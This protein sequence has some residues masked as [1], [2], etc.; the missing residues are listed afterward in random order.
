M[1]T[2]EVGTHIFLKILINKYCISHIYSERIDKKY[3][4]KEPKYSCPEIKL[5]LQY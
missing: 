2:M 5:G 3:K 4:S 1:N